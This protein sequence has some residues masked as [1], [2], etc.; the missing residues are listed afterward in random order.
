MCQSVT[1]SVRIAISVIRTWRI[2]VTGNANTS[3]IALQSGLA[4]MPI[5]AGLAELELGLAGAQTA[6]IGTALRA[7]G[8]GRGAFNVGQAGCPVAAAAVEPGQARREEQRRV[9][10]RAAG[11]DQAL[12]EPIDVDRR[13]A[14]IDGA[15]PV[16]ALGGEPAAR[17]RIA[18]VD[19]LLHVAIVVLRDAVDLPLALRRR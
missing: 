15:L 14:L 10:M 19:A 11:L 2:H 1:P 13:A 16:A 6:R 17:H 7:R 5:G 4:R 18:L 12:R 3:N 8:I 9:A